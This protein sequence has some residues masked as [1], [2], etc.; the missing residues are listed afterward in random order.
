MLETSTSPGSACSATRA[1]VWTAIPATFSV[2]D[3]AFAGVQAD[4]DV[5][6]ELFGLAP[7]R[8]RAANRACRPVE[9][10]EQ[11]V[12][13]HV[14]LLPACARELSPHHGAVPLEQLP[15]AAVAELDGASGRADD[16]D[17]E[18]GGEDAVAFLL[19]RVGAPHVPEDPPHTVSTTLPVFCPVST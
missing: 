13:R 15:P 9:G 2:D 19:D 1:P 16:V 7:D 11:P 17:E 18:H 8:A 6:A 3:L 5:E 10:R 4:A 14:D 12:A